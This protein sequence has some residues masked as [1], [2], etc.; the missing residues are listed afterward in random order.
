MKEIE[1]IFPKSKIE[2][3]IDDVYLIT[4]NDSIKLFYRHSDG[5]RSSYFKSHE[6]VVSSQN[7]CAEKEKKAGHIYALEYESGEISFFNPHL[8]E[9]TEK[10]DCFSY[11]LVTFDDDNYFLS[12]SLA[13]GIIR[14]LRITDLKMTGGLL[15]DSFRKTD[16][17]S[18]ILLE[19]RF[20][21]LN[22]YFCAKT[23]RYTSW[24][25]NE[26]KIN[27][28]VAFLHYNNREHG[29]VQVETRLF[30]FTFFRS[31]TIETCEFLNED[32]L[33][34]FKD[35]KCEIIRLSDCISSSSFDRPQRIYFDKKHKKVIR[36]FSSG[37]QWLNEKMEWTSRFIK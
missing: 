36:E 12:I 21:G 6:S 20:W 3:L 16:K 28:N 2:K 7:I 23:M 25:H 8:M 30:N 10:I 31:I 18:I 14:L 37:R 22:Q 11:R 27:D 33:L 17:P 26:K 35:D 32:Y 19:D 34:H 4:H 13:K 9:R 15:S 5:T 24:F 1:K 29:Q